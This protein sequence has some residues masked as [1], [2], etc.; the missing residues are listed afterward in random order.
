MFSLVT[1]F[2]YM[3]T[4]T[5][6]TSSSRHPLINHSQQPQA[7]SSQQP[8][9]T[10]ML[11]HIQSAHFTTTYQSATNTQGRI[12]LKPGSQIIYT[13]KPS[14]HSRVMEM[15]FAVFIR[16]VP[17]TSAAEI[18]TEEQQY[19]TIPTTAITNI[20]PKQAQLR[21]FKSEENIKYFN[22]EAKSTT[23]LWCFSVLLNKGIYPFDT[24]VTQMHIN[25]NPLMVQEV[26][27][28]LGWSLTEVLTPHTPPSHSLIYFDLY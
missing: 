22:T 25:S 10:R 18:F 12:N 28:L 9:A 21:W 1:C 2:T 14:E 6:Y 11:Y 8:Q 16:L 13:C 5:I 26:A 20:M 3:C 19:I 15:H 23:A 27:K 17:H 7:T 24:K 4:T